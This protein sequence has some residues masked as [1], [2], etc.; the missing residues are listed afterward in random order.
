MTEKREIWVLEDDEGCQFVYEQILGLRYVIRFFSKLQPF[1]EALRHERPRLFSVLADLRLPDG[2]FL[3]LLESQDVDLLR[4]VPYMVV[5]SYDD[6]EALKVCFHSGAFD[7]I[8]K[9][10]GK[11]ELLVKIERMMDMHANVHQIVQSGNVIADSE[12][13]TV[14]NCG[15][16]SAPLT[17]KEFQ[18]ITALTRAVR[19][20]LA[21]Q[22]LIYRVWG[23]TRVSTKTLDV[24]LFNLR[25]KIHPIDLEILFIAPNLYRLSNNRVNP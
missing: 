22:D 9:P 20:E 12:T 3:N 8:T 16:K 17:S 14:S 18:I 10:F 5:S 1:I 13:F 11:N 23:D 19:H 24:H 7:Y 2:N 25:R 21:R 4:A 15:I 6:L